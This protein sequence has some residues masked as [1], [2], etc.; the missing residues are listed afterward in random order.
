MERLLLPIRRQPGTIRGHCSRC[1]SPRH[2]NFRVST[3][4]GY[5]VYTEQLHASLASHYDIAI[6]LSS[7]CG[8]DI[9][10]YVFRLIQ[11]I[12]TSIYAQMTSERYA[13]RLS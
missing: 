4:V 8:V 11:R 12:L 3:R 2:K 10:L 6:S 7:L 1:M 5:R 13:Q 9:S